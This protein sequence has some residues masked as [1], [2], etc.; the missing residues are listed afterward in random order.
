MKFRFAITFVNKY[1][2]TVAEQFWNTDSHEQW[3]KEFELFL[4]SKSTNTQARNVD[5]VS[6]RSV[7][8]SA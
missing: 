3:W 7:W 5:T 8:N 2:Y 6:K 1:I 4:P